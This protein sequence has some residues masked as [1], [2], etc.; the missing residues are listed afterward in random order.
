VTLSDLF[1]GLESGDD[2]PKRRIGRGAKVSNPET[3]LD[4]GRL[5]KEVLS[6]ERA[7]LALKG[8]ALTSDQATARAPEPRSARSRRDKSS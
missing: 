6:A 8:M 3:S 2:G 5:L 4:R 1:L 7:I